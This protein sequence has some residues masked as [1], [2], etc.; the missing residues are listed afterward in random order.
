MNPT[1][2]ILTALGD[3]TPPGNKLLM[4]LRSDDPQR[5]DGAIEQVNTMLVRVGQ[6]L[7]RDKSDQAGLQPESIAMS[8][9]T[10]HLSRIT[11]ASKDDEELR[12]RLCGTM[13]FRVIDRLRKEEVRHRDIRPADLSSV[14]D[15]AVDRSG[16]LCGGIDSAISAN[17]PSSRLAEIIAG[18]LPKN[19]DQDLCRRYL[20]EG[21]SAAEVAAGLSLSETNVRARASRLRDPLAKALIESLTPH[22]DAPSWALARALL[23]SP[24][25]DL[26]VARTLGITLEAAK[27][28]FINRVI[29][30]VTATLGVEGVL[31]LYACLGAKRSSQGLDAG[32]F[33]RRD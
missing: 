21:K 32:Q 30:I 12:K 6:R 33:E 27:D 4:D 20:I 18:A 1:N 22:L 25:G 24:L 28:V 14:P 7:L 15:S 23:V 3:K 8:A 2:N 10:K 13:K 9:L 26:D 5:R 31:L 17:P 29:P 16:E 19:V 11:Q